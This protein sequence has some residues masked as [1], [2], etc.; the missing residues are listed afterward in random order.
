MNDR[1]PF[2]SIGIMAHNE[3]KNIGILLEQFL[4]QAENVKFPFEIT[5]V[6]SGCTD[7]TEEIARTYEN[8]DRRVQL[9]IEKQRK[10]KA[11]AINLFLNQAKG[12]LLII[13]SAD[14]I[15]AHNTLG[16][17]LKA[18]SDPK[19]G[20]VGGRPVPK[21]RIG[22]VSSLNKLL[23]ELHHEVALCRPKLGELIAIR[24]IID[25]IP[26]EAA[27]ADEAVLEAAII[28]KGFKMKY[29]PDVI[30]YNYAPENL[31]SLIKK[32]IRIFVGHLYVKKTMS[33]QVS[34]YDIIPL[35]AV[36]IKKLIKDKRHC[37][38]ILM[39]VCLEAYSRIIAFFE[40]YIRKR[41]YHIWKRN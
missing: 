35:A 18:F 27:A 1:K 37:L 17:F 10:G 23:W 24:N 30:I 29:L 3:K 16:E 25:K 9:L 22:I 40:Y 19:I 41:T 4:I 15:P 13:S 14:I 2:L 8:K 36:V 12:D 21:P 5:V 32:R 33:Y 31:I 6:A 38:Y 34:T 28:Q 26:E 11:S 39:L 20:M 7:R